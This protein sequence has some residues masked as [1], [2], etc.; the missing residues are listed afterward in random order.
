MTNLNELETGDFKPDEPGLRKAS[1]AA[2]I[3]LFVFFLVV[4]YV[5]SVVWDKA[6]EYRIAVVSAVAFLFFYGSMADYVIKSGIRRGLRACSRRDFETAIQEIEGA[7]AFLERH[8]WIDRYRRIIALNISAV[9]YRE[10]ALYNIASIHYQNGHWDEAKAV[11]LR[12]LQRFPENQIA[13]R[14]LA[15]IE[16]FE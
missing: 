13:K 2:R 4:G 1:I 9:G 5:S 8:S 7:Y 6:P 14:G 16:T 12:M 10:I 15:M 11:F 3:W